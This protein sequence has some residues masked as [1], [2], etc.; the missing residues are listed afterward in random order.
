MREQIRK[1]EYCCADG[2]EGIEPFP[3]PISLIY[4]WK[5]NLEFALG[6][7]YAKSEFVTITRYASYFSVDLMK[8]LSLEPIACSYCTSRLLNNKRII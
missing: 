8:A 2:C 6:I 1:S 4:L 5:V 3:S 7:P